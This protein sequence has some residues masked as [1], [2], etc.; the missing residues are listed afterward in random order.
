MAPKGPDTMADIVIAKCVQN[1]QLNALFPFLVL[2]GAH[3][4]SFYK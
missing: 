4:I 3:I 1:K 2:F